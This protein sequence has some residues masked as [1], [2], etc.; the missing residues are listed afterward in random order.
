MEV[1]VYVPRTVD[2]PD[3]YIPA[4]AKR[5][6]DCMGARAGEVSA[7]RGHLVRQAVQDGLVRELDGLLG[8]DGSVDL[9]CDPGA[10]IPLE[11]DNRSLSLLELLEALQY[12]RAWSDVT[13][14]AEA[15]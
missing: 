5:A 3:A 10:E 4:L 11:L 7:T 15:A 2:I 9:V 8:E 6:A 14:T 1:K 13:T 12:K